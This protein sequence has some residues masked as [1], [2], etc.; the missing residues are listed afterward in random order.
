MLLQYYRSV[1]LSMTLSLLK[2]K[3]ILLQTKP[4]CPVTTAKIAIQYI[5]IVYIAVAVALAKINP[6]LQF[7]RTL[8]HFHFLTCSLKGT[9]SLKATQLPV[10]VML[11]HQATCL[12]RG[13]GNSSCS[14]LH[15]WRCSF[16]WSSG[17]PLFLPSAD[18]KQPLR[19]CRYWSLTICE[20]QQC[21]GALYWYSDAPQRHLLALVSSRKGSSWPARVLIRHQ[22]EF[23][24]ELQRA[25]NVIRKIY[26]KRL[27]SQNTDL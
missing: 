17:Q 2:K 20:Q 1:G 8:S 6:C 14:A 13:S 15:C 24:R 23:K 11:L 9:Q 25:E 18:A 27:L 10:T 19:R 16:C 22:C 7:G 3:G 12:Q 5:Y 4:H 21:L 26:I